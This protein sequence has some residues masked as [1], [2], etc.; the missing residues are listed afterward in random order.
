[1]LSQLASVAKASFPVLVRDLYK[2]LL[3]TFGI[4][5]F[6]VLAHVTLLQNIPLRK[7]SPPFDLL[8]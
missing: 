7:S 8:L 6:L 1:M 2:N 5:N 4:S 3:Y